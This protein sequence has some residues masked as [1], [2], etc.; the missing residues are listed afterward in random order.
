[1]YLYV[2]ARHTGDKEGC[3]Y[4]YEYEEFEDSMEI[5]GFQRMTNW[6]Y[7]TAF[8]YMKFVEILSECK[9]K[10]LTSNGNWLVRRSMLREYK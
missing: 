5:P 2:D 10:G 3:N 6:K 8:T 4:I 9:G 1:M 7:Q